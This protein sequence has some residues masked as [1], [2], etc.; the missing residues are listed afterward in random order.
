MFG[1]RLYRSRE[2]FVPALESLHDREI[3]PAIA[4]GLAASVYTQLA[5]VEEEVNG[6]VTYDRRFVG[7]GFWSR[8]RRF[9]SSRPSSALDEAPQTARPGRAAWSTAAGRFLASIAVLSARRR[10]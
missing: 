4:R 5:D 10:E 1:Y 7:S 6:L 2:Q 8:D 9:E 3:A